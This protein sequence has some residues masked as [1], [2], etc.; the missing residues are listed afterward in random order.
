MAT[1]NLAVNRYQPNSNPHY[2]PSKIRNNLLTPKPI[3]LHPFQFKKN[4]STRRLH[5]RL[6]PRSIQKPSENDNEPS[7]APD[8][9]GLFAS[10][11]DRYL[12]EFLGLV[13]NKPQSSF[14]DP[15]S[16]LILQTLLKKVRYFTFSCDNLYHMCIYIYIFIIIHVVAKHS[17]AIIS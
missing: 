13:G 6:V 3:T 8:H 14:Y 16:F 4:I 17:R 7:K 12:Q 1:L 15:L 10:M 11:S 9:Q 2:D 5:R